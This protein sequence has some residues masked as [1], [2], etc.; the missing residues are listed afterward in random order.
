ML[1]ALT[2]VPTALTPDRICGHKVVRLFL[3]GHH[4][5]R[6][7]RSGPTGTVREPLSGTE[8][9]VRSSSAGRP[10]CSRHD[11]KFSKPLKTIAS[12]YRQRKPFITKVGWPLIRSYQSPGRLE[13]RYDG[14]R[15]RRRARQP[16]RPARNKK[17][18]QVFAA[19]P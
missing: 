15:P 7:T 2:R 6:G 16:G 18:R 17:R 14:A 9:P 13:S 3:P 5:S 8:R 4:R 12:G 19:I 11:T 10:L 1:F